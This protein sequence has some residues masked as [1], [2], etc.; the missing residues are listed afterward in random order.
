MQDNTIK[1]VLTELQCQ[2][3]FIEQGV[4]V[5]QPITQDSK[6]DYIV[7]INGKLYKIQCKSSS[8]STDKSYISMRT[9]TTNVRTMKD[10]FYSKDDIDYF[11]T[12]YEG[13]SYLIPVEISGH[14]ETRLRFF[15]NS[16][17]NPN[18]RWASDYEFN[19]ML[20]KIKEEVNS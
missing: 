4:L 19:L 10:T 14:G 7:D 5:S 11:Y 16:P 20:Q 3:D 18:I 8:L 15:S 9:K 1:G 17:N 6:Y 13:K 12:S 2:K